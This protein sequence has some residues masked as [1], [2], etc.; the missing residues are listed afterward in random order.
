MTCRLTLGMSKKEVDEEDFL[1]LKRQL[2]LMASDVLE[3]K[4][5]K[6]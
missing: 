2:L 3:N 6:K 4:E 1:F 5:G